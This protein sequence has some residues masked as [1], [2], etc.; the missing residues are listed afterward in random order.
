MTQGPRYRVAFRRRRNGRT[1]FRMRKKMILSDLPRLVVRGSLKH[2][3]AQLIEALPVGDKTLVHACSKE[4][5]EK[6]GWKAH[7]GN[8]PTAYLV[9]FLLGHKALSL[10][11]DRA[12]LDIGL[13]KPSKGMRAFTVLKGAV[14]AGLNTRHGERMMPQESRIRGEHIASYAEKLAEDPQLYEK[15]FSGYLK[16]D[17]RPEQI[18]EHFEGVENS[19]SNAFKE[20]SKHV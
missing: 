16:R 14:D 7:C 12:I 20:G 10:G 5:S 4:V 8:L 15:N 9:G 6:F 2:T 11:I 19:I 17:L 3:S 1:D 13:K 18:T